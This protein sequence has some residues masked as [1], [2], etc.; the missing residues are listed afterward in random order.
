MLSHFSCVWLFATLW[1]IA[2]QAPLSMGFSRQEHWSGLPF[3]SSK[4]TT[5]RKKVKSLS[6]AQFFATPWT[7]WNFPGRSTELGCHFLHLLQNISK[8]NLVGKESKMSLGCL[9]QAQWEPVRFLAKRKIPMDEKQTKELHRI[10][11]WARFRDTFDSFSL[12]PSF[13]FLYYQC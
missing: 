5:E 8:G 2:H 1:A 12:F 11:I 3:P 13:S 9:Q 4:G 6:H 7:P 10:R